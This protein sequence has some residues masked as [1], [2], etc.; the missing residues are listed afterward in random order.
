MEYIAVALRTWR[1]C[2]TPRSLKTVE[3]I[4]QLPFYYPVAEEGLRTALHD[5][6]GKI[7]DAIIEL[8]AA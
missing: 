6:Q 3:E 8:A 1:I 4:L 5:A 7:E 2:K